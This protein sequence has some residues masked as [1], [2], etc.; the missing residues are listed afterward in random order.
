MSRPSV[1]RT[2]LGAFDTAPIPGQMIVPRNSVEGPGLVA[3]NL[4]LSKS[5]TLGPKPEAGKKPAEDPKQL[6][7]SVNA[8]NLINHPNYGSPN[9]N[10]SSPL[11]GHSTSL[12]GGQGAA[13]RL[14]L[15]IRFDF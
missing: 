14:D 9:G 8:R 3:A 1:V 12:A 11:F 2:A 15:Q 13:R 5:I 7:F 6:T 10:L 4:R